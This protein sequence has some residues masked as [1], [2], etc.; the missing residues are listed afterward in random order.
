MRGMKMRIITCFGDW[1]RS[2]T[3]YFLLNCFGLLEDDNSVS[4]TSNF[5]NVFSSVTYPSV[6]SYHCV[7]HYFLTI[8]VGFNFN[9]TYGSNLQVSGFKIVTVYR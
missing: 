7:L 3:L 4:Q 2:S 5:M 9:L 8:P 6:F 1:T